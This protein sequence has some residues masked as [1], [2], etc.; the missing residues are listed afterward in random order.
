MFINSFNAFKN[1][2]FMC[3]RL[4]YNYIIIPLPFSPC[5]PCH[6]LPLSPFNKA[7]ALFKF[8]QVARALSSLFSFYFK[9]FKKFEEHKKAH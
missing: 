8:I 5:K 2:S 1:M 3:L 9:I 7:V 6:M 4:Q